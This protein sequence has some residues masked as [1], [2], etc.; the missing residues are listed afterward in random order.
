MKTKKKFFSL[1]NKF[2][3]S[4]IITVIIPIIFLFLHIFWFWKILDNIN[5]TFQNQLFLSSKNTKANPNILIVEIDDRTLRD[6]EKWWLGRWQDFDRANYARVIDNLTADWINIIWIDILFSEESNINSDSKLINSIE[7]AWNVVLAFHKSSNLYPFSKLEKASL[8]I[9]DVYAVVNRDNNTIY[10][11]VPFYSDTLEKTL[12]ISILDKYF[13]NIYWEKQKIK[14][15]KDYFDFY[16]KRIPF[17][18]KW[19]NKYN[20]EILINYISNKN[21]FNKIS[22]IDV[23]NNKYDHNLIKD[24]IVL[25]WSSATALHDEYNTPLGIIPWVYT[26]ANMINTILNNNTISFFN[27]K[28]EIIILFLFI[29]L[30]TILWVYDTRKYYFIFS[31]FIMIVIYYISY[32]SFYKNLNTILNFPTYFFIAI[33]LSFI[34]VNLYRYIYE[35]KGKRMLQNALSQ[36]LAEDLVAW[37]LHNFEKIKLGWTKM[38]NTIF[39]SDIAGFT[40]ISEKMEPE[41]LVRFLSH[42]LKEVSDVIIDNN[43]FINKYEWDAVMA[44][45]W[46]FGKQEEQTQQACRAAIDQQKIIEKLNSEFLEKYWF[47]IKVRMWL[48]RWEVIVGNIWSEWRKI[49]YTALGDNVNLASRLE[50]INKFYWTYICAAESVKNTSGNEFVWRYLDKIKVKWKKISSN[51]YELVWYRNEITQEKLDLIKK[52]EQALA[53]YFDKKF[54]EALKIFEELFDFQDIPS[55]IMIIRCKEFIGH[56]PGDSWDWSW[57]FD[58]K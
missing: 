32:T 46:T 8:W 5:T 41:E 42:Y 20:K 6:K 13:E 48:N 52:Y 50:W 33:I 19:S 38:V 21:W 16:D 54:V 35:D 47:K 39:F 44:L 51:I 55:S 49:E 57:E 53:L 40:T 9:G 22:F 7:K 31:M 26:H 36:Y 12:S 29:Y 58:E 34:L 27:Y 43:W 23:Y 28:Y 4:T 1:N 10:S 11:V 30:I 37:V 56:S 18:E 2:L 17:S 15:Y 3:V 14:I 25:I 24:K 45:W